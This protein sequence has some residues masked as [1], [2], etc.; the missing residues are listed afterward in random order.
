MKKP[1]CCLLLALIPL[2]GLAQQDNYLRAVEDFKA[3]YNKADT[4][5]IY[6][7]MNPG[8][9][10]AL[11]KEALNELMMSFREAYGDIQSVEFA[12]AGAQ[13]EVYEVTFTRGAQR[14]ALSLDKEDKLSGLRFLPSPNSREARFARNSTPFSLPFKG[15]WFT[16]WGGDTKAQNYHVISAAQ[17]GAFD[18]LV[19]GPNNKTYARSGTRNE[20]YYAFGQPIYAVCDAQVFDVIRGVADN[21]PGEMNP[22]QALGNS[23]T[24]L[25]PQGEYI[26]YAHFEQ[27]TIVVEKGQQVKRGQLLGKCGN[28]GNSS[29]AHL[30]LHLQDEGNMLTAVGA[31]SYFQRL[32]VNDSLHLDYSPVRLDRI[33]PIED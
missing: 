5:G 23:V 28:S 3:L 20:D 4:G 2:I 13:A 14:M 32:M 22:R 12:E 17:R 7:M 18:F 30:H 16:V 10:Q 15:K 19:L 6:E 11:E 21:K 29:E 26:V 27:G 24:L 8:M 25:T 33:S 31:K 9:Q 1:L